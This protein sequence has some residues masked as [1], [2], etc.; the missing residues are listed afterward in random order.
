MENIIETYK[1]NLE[2]KPIEPQKQEW[3]SRILK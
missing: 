2:W 3:P 1:A